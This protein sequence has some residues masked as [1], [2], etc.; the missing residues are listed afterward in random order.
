MICAE[1]MKQ[2]RRNG[3]AFDRL[4]TPTGSINTTVLCAIFSSLF[5]HLLLQF[6]SNQAP[7]P[8]WCKCGVNLEMVRLELPAALS[9]MGFS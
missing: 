6:M 2:L 4:I 9:T 3:L 8:N 7:K 5:M 1:L